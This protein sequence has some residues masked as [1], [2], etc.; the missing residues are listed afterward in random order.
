MN[1]AA[2]WMAFFIQSKSKWER[3]RSWKQKK[4]DIFFAL[5]NVVSISSNMP[6]LGS[7]SFSVLKTA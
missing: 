1:T 2:F 3:K 5:G 6:L 4:F 7:G